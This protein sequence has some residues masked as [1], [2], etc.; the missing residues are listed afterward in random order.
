MNDIGLVEAVGIVIV[1][2][3]LSWPIVF[4]QVVRPRLMARI[5]R[6]LQVGVHESTD[7]WDA[8]LYDAQDGAPLR[9]T[10]AVTVADFVVTVLGVVG[11][12]T[13]VS[14]PLFLF[15]E[16]GLP[17]R[18][19]GQINGTAVRIA[20]I[21]VPPM[22]DDETT[23]RVTV[24]SEAR[25]GMKACRLDVAGYTARNGYLNGASHFFDLEPA[26]SATIDLKLDVQRRIPG[27]HSIRVN[28]ECGMRLKDSVSTSV[29][30]PR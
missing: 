17:Y 3:L 15:V 12:M 10:L 28:L 4:F 14:I 22:T 26:A 8:G 18:W 9:K 1:L 5:G 6:W 19:E 20:G 23:A 16:T 11:V 2:V 29:D 25:A 13:A 27:T 21:V 24:H 30:V 7:A